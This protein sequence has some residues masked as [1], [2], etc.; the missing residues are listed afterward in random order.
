MYL[1]GN[2]EDSFRINGVMADFPSN[3]HLDYN[4]FISLEGV[5]F[6]KGEQTRWFQNNYYTY[7]ILKAGTDTEA[8][9]KKMSNT[10]IFDYMKPA[11]L[12][13]GFVAGESLLWL[14]LVTNP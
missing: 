3:S 4:F 5:E 13:A 10:L 11:Y 7:I 9:E 14:P 8:F 6:G 2:T 1:N 12:A